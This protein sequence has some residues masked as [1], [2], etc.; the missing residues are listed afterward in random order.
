[1]RKRILLDNAEKD[2]DN[3]ISE[4]AACSISWRGG[5]TQG[6]ESEGIVGGIQKAGDISE[7]PEKV[8]ILEGIDRLPDH[9]EKG[10]QTRPQAS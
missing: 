5:A 1:M 2:I 4:S 10:T 3:D 8:S 6:L 7:T 9:L